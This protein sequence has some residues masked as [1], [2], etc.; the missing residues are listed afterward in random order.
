MH[1]LYTLQLVTHLSIPDELFAC[2]TAKARLHYIGMNTNGNYTTEIKT[3][4]HIYEYTIAICF[5]HYRIDIQDR[6]CS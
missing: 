2:C 6:R 4:L 5:V 3:V 1:T